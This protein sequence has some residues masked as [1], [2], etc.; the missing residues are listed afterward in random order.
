VNY[1]TPPKAENARVSPASVSVK[2]AHT[3]VESEQTGI[4]PNTGGPEGLLLIGG[5]ALVAVGGTAVVVAR[6]RQIN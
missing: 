5:L 6:R 3:S 2:S 4:L 1:V